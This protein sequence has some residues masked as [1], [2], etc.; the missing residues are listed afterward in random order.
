MHPEAR[1]YAQSSTRAREPER[2]QDATRRSDYPRYERR[3]EGISGGRDDSLM[4]VLT[5]ER[6]RAMA[7][8]M[9]ALQRGMPSTAL[10][11]GPLS[12]PYRATSGAHRDSAIYDRDAEARRSR[13]QAPRALQQPSSMRELEDAWRRPAPRSP[14]RYVDNDA[15]NG[16]S[17]RMPRSPPRRQYYYDDAGVNT[18]IPYASR[19]G[20]EDHNRGMLAPSNRAAAPRRYHSVS[21]KDRHPRD[22][23]PGIAL[24]PRP[25]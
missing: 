16:Y 13:S 12:P 21:D 20:R 25:R 1:R 24:M 10:A 2:T 23:P 22:R 7:D 11:Q 15:Y 5:A 18:D 3:A 6:L 19:V 4:S 17:T 8:Q 14:P 9:E